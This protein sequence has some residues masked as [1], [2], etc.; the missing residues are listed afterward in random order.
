MFKVVCQI[1]R[2]AKAIDAHNS[3]AF[4]L[5]THHNVACNDA[6]YGNWHN[7]PVLSPTFI[8]GTGLAGASVSSIFH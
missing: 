8:S 4:L 3:E 5:L 1:V 7:E 6:D 2:E